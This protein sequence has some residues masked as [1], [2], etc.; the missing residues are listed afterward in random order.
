MLSTLE[1]PG[2]DSSARSTALRRGTFAATTHAQRDAA[3]AERATKPTL[4]YVGLPSCLGAARLAYDLTLAPQS[5]HPG[6]TGA[7]CSGIACPVNEAGQSCN[8]VGTCDTSTGTCTCPAPYSGTVRGPRASGQRLSCL[9]SRS[10]L[11]DDQLP[12]RVLRSRDVLYW[13]V[14]LYEWVH[15]ERLLGDSVQ[16][17][18][19]QR[20]RAVRH[21]DG[22]VRLQHS[23]QRRRPN[24]P[25][26][27]P[28]LQRAAAPGA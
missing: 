23:F 4:A 9:P 28:G 2:P 8:G 17:S 14:Q 5:C 13:N 6:W 16:R 12:E 3:G 22:S 27:K 18:N 21:V 20:P 11:R 25:V 10:G 7:D 15:A 26:C 1:L 24:S 19:V